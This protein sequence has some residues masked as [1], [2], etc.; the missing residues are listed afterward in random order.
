MKEKKSRTYVVRVLDLKYQSEFKYFAFNFIYYKVVA[1]HEEQAI[2]KANSL[3][4][5]GEGGEFKQ[6]L[7]ILLKIFSIETAQT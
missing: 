6:E 2:T 3:Y 4:M 1:Q 7:P 5:K